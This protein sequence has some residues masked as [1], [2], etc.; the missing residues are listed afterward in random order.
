MGLF[1]LFMKNKNVI[2]DNGLNKIY[3]DNGKGALKEQ[4]FKINGLIDGEFISYERNGTYLKRHYMNGE[5]CLTKEE[6]LEKNRQEEINKIIQEQIDSFLVL[7]NLIVDI[8]NIS[9]LIQM[10][11]RTI[12]I[13]TRWICIKLSNRFEEEI[14]KFYLFTKRNHFIRDLILS[15]DETILSDKCFKEIIKDFPIKRLL[16]RRRFEWYN[17][18]TKEQILDE[19]WKDMLTGR[20]LLYKFS[21]WQYGFDESIF[22]QESVLFGLNLKAYK[23]IFDVLKEYEEKY[24]ECLNGG[25][26]SRLFEDSYLPIYVT[27]ETIIEKAIIE[28]NSICDNNRKNQEEIILNL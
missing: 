6:Q 15:G 22:N 2:T 3:Y 10:D 8:I 1:D 5:R 24:G 9:Q 4:F 21:I 26:S 16:P 14:I 28:I 17:I 13:Y 18:T 7:D 12:E 27:E 20:T 23:L 11:N 19:I 25:F